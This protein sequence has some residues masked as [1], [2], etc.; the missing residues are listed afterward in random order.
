MAAL[1]DILYKVGIRTVSGD[2][3]V[4]IT[5]VQMDSR[6]VGPR[7]CFIAV[8]GT[9]TDGHRYIVD[10]IGKR[11]DDPVEGEEDEAC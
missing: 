11:Y 1:R 10:A 6:L 9:A 8:R 4:E 2:T 5:D 3:A 7:C